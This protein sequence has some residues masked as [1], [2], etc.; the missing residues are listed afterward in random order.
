MNNNRIKIK[1]NLCNI[2]IGDNLPVHLIAEIGLNHNGSVELAKKMIKVAAYSGAT[3]VKFQK[4]NPATLASPEY[5]NAPFEKCPS[6]G[7][8]Q[9]EVRERL[10]LSKSE[11][12][13]LIEYSEQLGVIFFAS[14]FDLESLNFLTDLNI[15]IIKLASHSM[16]NGPLLNRIA[17]LGVPIMCSLG[18]LTEEEIEASL[19]I[20]KNNEKVIM[21]CVSS[22]P[23]KD[24]D[25]YL[26]TIT[27]LKKGINAPIG[28]SSH[29]I[30]TDMSLAAAALGATII[31]RHFTI[32]RAMIGL[33]QTISLNPEEFSNLAIQLKRLYQ[34]RGVKTQPLQDEINVK[35]NYHVG[36]YTT[37]ELIKG[38]KVREE[39]ICC[40]QPLVS[41]SEFFTGLEYS[42]LIG[43]E[44]LVDI[45]QTSIVPRS[46]IAFKG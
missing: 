7:S 17:E 6:M 10:E 36:V 8:T 22:Y 23:T 16:T 24:S 34:A 19:S 15:P 41:R 33:D 9:L 30:G 4:R 29:E 25:I 39:D 45:P 5:L 44:V 20:L 32:N 27:K 38:S 21:H 26:D 40:M 46:S 3:F 18:G 2:E 28:Y 11:Y 37:R 1:T 14:A 43:A 42:S 12:L 31:E 35:N 13:E